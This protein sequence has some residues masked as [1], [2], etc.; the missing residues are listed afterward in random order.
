MEDTKEE[1]GVIQ[2]ESGLRFI[3]P[4]YE[5][6][7]ASMGKLHCWGTLL[8]SPQFTTVEQLGSRMNELDRVEERKVWV[9]NGDGSCPS[10]A[11]EGFKAIVSKI[12]GKTYSVVSQDY[13]PIDDIQVVKPLY[14]FA[15]ERGLK[16]VG[17]FDAI[18]TGK[19][20]GHVIL[21]NPEF[22]VQ[23]LKEYPDPIMLGVVIKNSYNT[24]TSYGAEVFGVRKVCCNFNLWGVMLGAFHLRHY[25]Q[26]GQLLEAYEEL[27]ETMLDRIPVFSDKV[28]AAANQIVLETE[29][30]DLLWGVK[31]PI[32]GIEQIVSNVTAFEPQVKEVGLNAWTLYNATT[33]W[34][35]HR[36]KSGKYIDATSQH[37]RNAVDL[38]TVGHDDLLKRGIESRLK[39]EE[40]LKEAKGEKQLVKAK[41]EV[42]KVA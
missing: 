1:P 33:A 12:S 18:G 34:I 11:S 39:Y 22:E 3:E 42:R 35:T 26:V 10:D 17:R 29:V 40:K 14:D 6:A 37:A 41:I 2:H 13:Q 20:R 23:I 32:T 7:R 36:E 30:Q 25:R 9:A 5:V 27:I 16:P 31:L 15:M 4:T 19:T 21:A 24:E 8:N 38:L 28:Q